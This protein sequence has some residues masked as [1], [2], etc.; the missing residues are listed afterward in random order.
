MLYKISYMSYE[1]A[2]QH[3]PE[4]LRWESNP[5]SQEIE[6]NLLEALDISIA[7]E[8][9]TPRRKAISELYEVAYEAGMPV[10]VINRVYEI[11]LAQSDKPQTEL[12]EIEYFKVDSNEPPIQLWPYPIAAA[13]AGVFIQRSSSQD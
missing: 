9:R 12:D 10:T 11:A 8:D 2:Y 1:N 7:E 3:D 4:E 5:H 6:L 13:Q